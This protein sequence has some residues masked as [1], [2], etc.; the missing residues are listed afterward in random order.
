MFRLQARHVETNWTRAD[1]RNQGKLPDSYG[2]RLL[3]AHGTLGRDLGMGLSAFL[4]TTINARHIKG[5]EV[6]FSALEVNRSNPACFGSALLRPND[7]R[8]LIGMEHSV[9]FPLIGIALGAKAGAFISPDRQP[10]EIELQVVTLLYRLVLSEVLR[11]WQPV[12]NEQLEPVT[13]GIEH[14]PLKMFP[15]AHPVFIARFELALGENVGNL[16]LVAPPEI[17]AKAMVAEKPREDQDRGASAESILQLMLPAKVSVD[18]WLEGSHMQ[19]RDLF[20]LS[21]GQIVKLDHPVERKATCTLNGKAS[22]GGQ[23]VSTG[24]RRAFLIEDAGLQHP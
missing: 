4:R 19:L 10:T 11:A 1:F 24:A 20:Q 15:Q 14:S 12:I 16:L 21:P 18:V 9:L 6:S 23:I 22:F 17:F 5:E 7:H 3:M 8:L 2:D 13:F